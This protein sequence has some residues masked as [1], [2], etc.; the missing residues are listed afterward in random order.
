MVKLYSKSPIPGVVGPL[1]NGLEH[2]LL[3]GGF[4]PFEKY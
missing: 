3:G 4:S 2:G 1:P